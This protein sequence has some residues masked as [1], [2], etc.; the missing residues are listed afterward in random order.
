MPTPHVEDADPT[1]QEPPLGGWPFWVG[2]ASMWRNGREAGAYC[3][4]LVAASPEKCGIV[5][6]PAEW[7]D[8]AVLAMV[9]ASLSV[10]AYTSSESAVSFRARA[11][12][13]VWT[14][15]AA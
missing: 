7:A 8:G 15:P 14:P 3:A 11:S 10:E 2:N 4:G 1:M 12:W 6:V 13:L 5:E 9:A